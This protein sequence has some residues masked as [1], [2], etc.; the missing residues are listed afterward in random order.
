MKVRNPDH[1]RMVERAVGRD[2]RK[3]FIT[4]C[5]EDRELL[6]KLKAQNNWKSIYMINFVVDPTKVHQSPVPLGPE[7]KR[8]GVTHYIRDMIDADQLIL[9]MLCDMCKINQIAY[10]DSSVDKNRDKIFQ[11]GIRSACQFIMPLQL[12]IQ[13]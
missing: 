13:R 1:A 2:I 10:G 6:E 5:V 4:Q 11:A 8:L 9:D 7:L 12:F 3:A